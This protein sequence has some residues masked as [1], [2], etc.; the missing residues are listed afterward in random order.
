[1]ID[2][3]V[4]HGHQEQRR[5][6]GQQV[7]HHR[8]DPEL[9]Q[10]RAQ[11]GEH[12]VTQA[13]LPRLAE[14]PHQHDPFREVGDCVQTACRGAPGAWLEQEQMILYPPGRD[15]SLARHPADNQEGRRRA[16]EV[17]PAWLE[18]P[19]LEA[20]PFG[21]SRMP[22]TPSP[23]SAVGAAALISAR[24]N[25]RS[26][27]RHSWANAWI[28]PSEVGAAAVVLRF[29]P[30]PPSARCTKDRMRA[31]RRARKATGD[32]RRGRNATC[33]RRWPTEL[34][35]TLMAPRNKPRGYF[36]SI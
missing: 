15:H 22:P 1:M 6:Q 9:P 21:S 28:C 26:S 8:G 29:G 16:G 18:S 17:V 14:R 31:S 27:I 25:G 10:H 34:V 7:D 20:E 24:A 13:R 11:P 19:H 5:R 2:H 32:K 4:V 12:G 33:E 36:L 30:R 23:P 3:L 35:R